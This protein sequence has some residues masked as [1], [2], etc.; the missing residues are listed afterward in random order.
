MERSVWT[1]ERIDDLATALDH[2]FELVLAELHGLRRDMREELGRMRAD[3]R[4]ELGAMR[5]EF[6]TREEFG[7]L[8]GE[9]GAL[10]GE[11]GALRVEL[12]ND[13]R[14]LRSEM[15]ADRRLTAQIGFGLTGALLAALA[16]MLAALL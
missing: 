4:D 5:G 10:R 14:E 13:M 2:K 6:A 12:H 15:A 3:M 1:D 7:A 8:R 16:G 9:F 11:V